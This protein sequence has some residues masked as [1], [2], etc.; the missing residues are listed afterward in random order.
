MNSTNNN[1][2]AINSN[3]SNQ[4]NNESNNNIRHRI[5]NHQLESINEQNQNDSN[6]EIPVINNNS[7]DN[8][9]TN[10]SLNNDNQIMV[11]NSI[12]INNETVGPVQVIPASH[13]FISQRVQPL[14]TTTII[15]VELTSFLLPLLAVVLSCGWYIR[16]NFK[17]F[18][19][20]LSTLILIIFTF[21]YA[22]FLLNNIHT[23]SLIAVNNIMYRTRVL[24]RRQQQQQQQ[25][26]IPSSP[27]PIQTPNLVTLDAQ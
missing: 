2:S 12:V 13:T 11:N 1:S 3:L 7:N 24:Q 26:Q 8:A 18:F 25:Q 17:N 27:S 20:P 14:R 6:I 22:L 21:I 23:N 19:S 16:V 4:I 10:A 15:N 9:N 5:I